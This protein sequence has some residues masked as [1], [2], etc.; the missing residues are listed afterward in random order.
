MEFEVGDE[1]MVR[2][3][4]EL[5]VFYRKQKTGNPYKRVTLS[6]KGK[7]LEVIK[8]SKGRVVSCK[9]GDRE[10]WFYKEELK[11]VRRQNKR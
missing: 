9:H 5:D 1:V 3:E 6:Y 4:E 7:V 2:P 8:V 10:C 11:F